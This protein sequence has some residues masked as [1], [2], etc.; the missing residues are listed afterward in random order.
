MENTEIMKEAMDTVIEDVVV[1]DVVAKANGKGVLLIAGAVLAV[2]AAGY[3]LGK[4]AYAAYKDKK[5]LRQ[6]DKEIIVEAEDLA[7]VTAE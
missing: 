2:A 3:A 1:D 5:A 4:K 7:E 6:P